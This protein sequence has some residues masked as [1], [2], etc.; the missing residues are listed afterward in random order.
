VRI[1]YPKGGYDLAQLAAAAVALEGEK[2]C[3]YAD[4]AA[5]MQ[6]RGHSG[7]AG[8]FGRLA[9]EAALR[10]TKLEDWSRSLANAEQA[11]RAPDLCVPAP[12]DDEAGDL[13]PDIVTPYQ[14]LAIAVRSAED[15]FR[16]Y[17]HFASRAEG[18]TVRA[19]AEALAK[20]AL[21]HA[22]LLRRERRRAYRSQ[23]HHPAPIQ[24][25][26]PSLVETLADLLFA[27]CAIEREIESCLTAVASRQSDLGPL[28]EAVRDDNKV[29]EKES[30]AAGRPRHALDLFYQQHTTA[31][32]RRAEGRATVAGSLE[33]ALAESK[34]A[35]AFYDAVVAEASKEAVMLKAQ[36][37][38]ETALSR[39]A[40]LARA[41]RG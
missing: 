33:R 7:I 31:R 18:E 1:A 35:F 36:S 32:M 11:A 8:F 21:T 29:L 20:G 23:L 30:L 38:S 27:A 19:Q 28:C 25:P 34:R 37:L 3:Y 26:A 4:L 17:S 22:A 6:R 15:V 16:F 13:D 9:S 24:L 2:G 5:V 14:A 40:I 41:L 12:S 39:I 10:H